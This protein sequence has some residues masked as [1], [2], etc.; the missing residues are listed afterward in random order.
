MKRKKEEIDSESE[1][2][3]EFDLNSTDFTKKDEVSLIFNPI[4][5]I[6]LILINLVQH[7]STFNRK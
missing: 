3:M 2:N 4:H 6:L 7:S 1:I 5:F